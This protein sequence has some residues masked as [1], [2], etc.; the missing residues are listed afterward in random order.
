M[1]G[2]DALSGKGAACKLWECHL[3]CDDASKLEF[4]QVLSPG[5]FCFKKGWTCKVKSSE[6]CACC[7]A[8]VEAGCTSLPPHFLLAGLAIAKPC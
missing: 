3:R 7:R 6:H 1:H 5:N 8:L 2:S 4:L